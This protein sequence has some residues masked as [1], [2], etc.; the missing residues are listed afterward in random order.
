MRFKLFTKNEKK[1]DYRK[2]TFKDEWINK[3]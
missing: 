2:D 3:T 1:N